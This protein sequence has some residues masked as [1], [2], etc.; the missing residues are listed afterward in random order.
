V[1]RRH[2]LRAATASLT[3][4][5]YLSGLLFTALVAGGGCL[6]NEYRISRDEL[7]RLAQA[8]LE[9]R[10]RD[11][12][13]LQDV[14]SRRDGE[15]EPPSDRELERAW[16]P[17]YV[18]AQPS[19]DSDSDSVDAVDLRLDPGHAPARGRVTIQPRGLHRRG[20]RLG[21]HGAV[22]TTSRGHAGGG[23]MGD[24]FGGGG[25]HSG[26]GGG[27]GNAG[28]EALVMLAILAVAIAGVVAVGLVASEGIRFQGSAA[29]APDQTL[30]VEHGDGRVHP[31]RLGELTPSDLNHATG[32]VVKDDEGYGIALGR[33]DPLDRRGG[34][35][36][37]E[38]GASSFNLGKLRSAGPAAEIQVGGFF[39]QRWGLMLDLGVSGGDVVMGGAASAAASL[40][41]MTQI[42]TRHH[43]ALELQSFPAAWGPL[44]LG[45]F[46]RAGAALAGTPDGIQGGP[47]AGGGAMM[48][49]E[50][51]T[52]LALVLRGGVDTA[53]LNDG[54][55]TAASLTGG[56]AV[57]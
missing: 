17:L 32:A 20:E 7:Q 2:G 29:M 4:I 52:R 44:H 1:P 51:T 19:F 50:L 39:H 40:A 49:L 28:G 5:A 26:G 34:A 55:S 14:G 38:L 42:V 23:S 22:A 18:E 11:V 54:W 10:G 16:Q 45:L 31:V 15:I 37:L 35:F 48:Q 6:S 24:V 53:H 43:V 41:D 12:H 8:P 33:R 57:Y 21:G 36:N 46:A 27:G 3:T 56:I 13:M 25:S 9:T 47:L 30:Y